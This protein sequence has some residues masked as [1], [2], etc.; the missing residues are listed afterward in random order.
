MTTRFS[1]LAA[2]V[3]TLTSL[4]LGGCAA[5][6]DA[7]SVGEAEST[8]SERESARDMHAEEIADAKVARTNEIVLPPTPRFAEKDGVERFEVV[9][10]AFGGQKLDVAMP[11]LTTR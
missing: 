9:A 8:V 5:D 11:A 3:V 4:A 2:L 7:P 6:A 10:P 1:S